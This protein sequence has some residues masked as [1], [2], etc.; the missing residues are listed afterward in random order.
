MAEKLY[1]HVDLGEGTTILA[2]QLIVDDKLGRFKYANA[3][4]NHPR[5]FALDPIN[6]PLTADIHVKP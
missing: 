6:L 3:Y 1:V 5:A 4:I 2:G